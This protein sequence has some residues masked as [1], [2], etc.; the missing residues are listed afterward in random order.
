MAGMVFSQP[1]FKGL[2]VSNCR[3]MSEL[4]QQ[5]QMMFLLSKGDSSGAMSSRG[6]ERNKTERK[7]AFT[8]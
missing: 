5:K 7:E 1:P 6:G 4:I 8:I 2:Q 3:L